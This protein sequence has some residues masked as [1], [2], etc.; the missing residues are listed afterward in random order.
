MIRAALLIALM[1]LGLGLISGVG[2]QTPDTPAPVFIVGRTYLV[3]PNLTSGEQVM[4]TRVRPDGW[5]ETTDDKGDV[6]LMNP[7]QVYAVHLLP[8]AGQLAAR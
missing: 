5:V 2:G 8:L 1:V 3:M 7:A 6:W 4:V